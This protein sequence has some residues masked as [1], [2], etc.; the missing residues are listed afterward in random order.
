M[1]GIFSFSIDISEEY[2]FANTED[3][4]KKIGENKWVRQQWPIVYFIK[5]QKLKIAYIGEST[6]ALSRLK[7]H[8]QNPE[9]NGLNKVSIISSDKFNKSATLDIESNLIQYFS[10]EGTY[11]LQ[12][13]NFGI[14]RHNYYQSDEYKKL[15]SH[16]WDKLL[17]KKVV[18]KTREQVENSEIFKYSPYKSLN[19]GQFQAL[20]EILQTLTND[21]HSTIF[22]EGSAGTGKTILATYLIKLL[23]TEFNKDVEAE[24]DPSQIEN[25]KLVKVLQKAF[26]KKRI[27]LVIAMTAL[28]KTLVNVFSNV[29]GLKA[30]MILSPS[31]TFK[32]N[33]KYDLLIV[34]EAHRLR[35]YKNIGWM[36]VFKK[37]NQSIGLDDSGTELDWIMANS[38]NQIFFYDTAQS[39]K[40]SDISSTKFDKLLIGRRTKRL[41]LTEQMRVGGGNNYIE[42][43]DKLL[44]VR[45][46]SDQ[47]F[48][49][50]N[51]ELLLFENFADLFEKLQKKENEH[52]LC[53]MIAGYSW[54]WKSNPKAKPKPAANVTDIELD[55]LSFKWNSVV[56]DWIN[57]ENAFNE[58]G[59]IHT[60][61]GYDLNYAAVIFGHEIDYNETTDEITIDASKYYD[62][63]GKKG[64]DNPEDLKSYVINIYKTILFRGIKGTYVYACNKGLRDYLSLHVKKIEHKSNIRTL[65]ALESNSA[66]NSVPYF[67]IQVAAGD[68]S[69]KHLLNA[70]K[71]IALPE[72]IKARE[73]YFVCKVTGES[74]NKEIP[75]GSLCLFKIYEGGTRN[76]ATVI[77]QCTEIGDPD[78]GAGYTVKKYKSK[79]VKGGTNDSWQ[80]SQIELLPNSLDK[81]FKPIVLKDEQLEAFKVIGELVQ[82]LS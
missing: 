47:R 27:G 37:N 65:H 28:R 68:F 7:N 24:L 29:P 78:F 12:N 41:P 48:T 15:F 36:G 62:I 44:H 3:S 54:P 34:D 49:S 9:R 50:E 45:L 58:I 51:Y 69:P 60:T 82:L 31:D 46:T 79:K 57:S 77:V 53:R 18:A 20:T 16:I 75:N 1:S 42:F 74:M 73:G 32:S 63:N 10:A 64:I 52:E 21:T 8:L 17:E 71:R 59:C 13:G 33:E 66:E 61:Q 38:K 43:I 11:K 5:N 35:Q 39:V 67:D 4:L 76:G 6:N 2:D 26:P 81:R 72:T 80:H 25:I 19:D 55:G 23:V 30:S 22:I 56:V 14:Q 40:P 70:T